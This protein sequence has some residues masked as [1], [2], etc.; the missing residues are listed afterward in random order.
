MN[1]DTVNKVFSNQ[2][3][4]VLLQGAIKASGVAALP[5]V[6]KYFPSVTVDSLAGD[7]IMAGPFVIGLA[8]DWYRNHP[9]NILARAR[10][11]IDGGAASAGAVAAVAAQAAAADPNPAKAT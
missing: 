5:F 3:F 4:Q 6:Q 1:M 2:R 9:D 7:V 10:A 11:V 8:I